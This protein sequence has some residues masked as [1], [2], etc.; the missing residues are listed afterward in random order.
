MDMTEFIRNADS[1][2]EVLSALSVYVESLRHVPAIPDWCRQL[3]IQ[4]EE[5]VKARMLAIIAV[6]N[7]TSQN[8]RDR[9]CDNAKS[10]LRV[11]AAACWQLRPRARRP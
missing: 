1:A 2:A 5:D 3:P 4:G 10:A 9:D 8:L 6:V 7:L 11:F